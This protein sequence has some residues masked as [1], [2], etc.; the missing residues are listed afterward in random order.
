VQQYL[1]QLLGID[2]IRAKSAVIQREFQLTDKLLLCESI[3][4]FIL[5]HALD[6]P[7]PEL[8][9]VLCDADITGLKHLAQ[10]HRQQMTAGREQHMEKIK[11]DLQTRL[12]ITG[13][14]VEPNLSADAEW[15]Q[16]IQKRTA[17]LEATL[18]ELKSKIHRECAQSSKNGLDSNITA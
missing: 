5:V 7:L 16:E 15:Q 4:D 2:E 9:A 18:L 1:D 10:D 14:A 6:G 8:L 12:G 11:N 17:D 13:S 3:L